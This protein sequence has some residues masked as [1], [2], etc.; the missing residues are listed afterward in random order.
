MLAAS[1]TSPRREGAK[2][3]HRGRG[4][5]QASTKLTLSSAIP[6]VDAGARFASSVR[7]GFL[8]NK[9]AEP[10]NTYASKR[11]M[12]AVRPIASVCSCITKF[13]ARLRAFLLATRA[14]TSTG[15]ARPSGFCDRWFNDNA[16]TT[17]ALV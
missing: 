8:R 5:I 15:A 3:H 14:V 6:K 13:C 1:A 12:R 17:S 10:H 11:R 9:N 7:G 2:G 16:D 4:G